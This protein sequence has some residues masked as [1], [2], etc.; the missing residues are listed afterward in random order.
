MS[1]APVYELSKCPYIA[2][3]ESLRVNH[4]ITAP[5]KRLVIQVR[6]TDLAPDPGAP[7][8][9]LSYKAARSLITQLKQV[10]DLI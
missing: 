8:L 6:S 1:D 10:C 4:I 5:E 2:E 3:Q 9:A 7:V